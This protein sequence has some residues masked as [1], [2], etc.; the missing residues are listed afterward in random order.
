ILQVIEEIGPLAQAIYVVDDGCPQESGAH[1]EAQCRDERVS[2]LRCEKNLGIGGAMRKGYQKAL[3]DGATLVVKMDGYGQMDAAFLPHLVQPLLNGFA[4]YTKGNRFAA[5][6]QMR[7]QLQQ[8]MPLL[9]RFGNSVL[10]FV[11]KSMSGYW[12]IMD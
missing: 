10:S 6:Y 8:Q 4:D 12:N 5:P 7:W 9:R 11:H 1:V 3:Q 2:V